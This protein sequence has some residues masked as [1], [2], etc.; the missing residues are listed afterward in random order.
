MTIPFYQVDVFTDHIFGGNPL[1]VFPEGQRFAEEDLIK[2]ARE[3]NLSETTFV[4]PSTHAEADFNVRIFT[5]TQELPFAGHPT[6]GTT[7]VLRELKWVAPEK[8]PIRLNFKVGIISVSREGDKEFMEHPPAKTLH[9]LNSDFAVCKAL[10]LTP[11]CI[12]DSFPIQVVSTGFPALIVPIKSINYLNKININS[13][14]LHEILSPLGV[15]MIYPFCC[16]TSNDKHTIHSRGFAPALG[17]PEDPATGSVAG[18]MG[19]YWANF[20]DGENITM[21]I[22]QGYAMGRPSLI[23]VEIKKQEGEIKNIRVGGRSK[24]VFF[25]QME[26]NG[27]S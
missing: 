18:A 2:I 6:L 8:N 20:K 25:G 22:E 19:A 4:Y 11:D 14:V 9:H 15:D 10:G 21:V 23:T 17:I 13:E 7:H 26:Q 1:A 5:P 24:N 12:D 27:L 3:M 16:E